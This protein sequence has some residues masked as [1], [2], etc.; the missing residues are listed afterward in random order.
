MTKIYIVR[1]GQSKA[2][3]KDLFLGHGNLDLTMLGELQAQKT[4]DFLDGVQIDK[5]YSSDLGR[6]VQTAEFTANKKGLDIIKDVRLR[7]IDAGE[8]DFMTFAEIYKKSPNELALWMNDLGRA[9]CPKGETILQSQTRMF[10]AIKDIAD[11]NPKKTIAIFSH[12][13]SILSFIAKVKGLS[14]DQI[15][16]MSYPS[17]A[18]VTTITY[19]NGKF[20]LLEYSKDDF[21]G[22]LRTALPK[23]LV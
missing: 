1:H 11:K 10:D 6:A 3:E 2:N 15:K 7:E 8:W 19:D 4:A 20:E 14:V 22:D 5:I 23:N 13:T 9:Y 16:T 21:M 12:A 18:S 17:N